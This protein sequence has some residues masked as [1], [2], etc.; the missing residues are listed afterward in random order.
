VSRCV[1]RL[2]QANQAHPGDRER[3]VAIPEP[4][5]PLVAGFEPPVVEVHDGS[6]LASV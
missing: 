4:H 5:N 6:G 3:S 1:F 2:R